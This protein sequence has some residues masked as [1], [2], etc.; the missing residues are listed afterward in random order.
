MQG[1]Y[2]Y[3]LHAERILILYAVVGFVV[4]RRRKVT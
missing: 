4:V 1:N 3:L 2:I